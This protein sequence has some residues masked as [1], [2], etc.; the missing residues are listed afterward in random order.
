[1]PPLHHVWNDTQLKSAQ[2]QD[3]EDQTKDDWE[4]SSG[5]APLRS[6]VAIKYT[7]HWFF[8]FGF[9]FCLDR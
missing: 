1:M 2:F 5:S 6:E 3:G 8:S 7:R 4:L 9:A